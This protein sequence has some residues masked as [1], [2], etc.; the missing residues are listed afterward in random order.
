MTFAWPV[1]HLALGLLA[2]EARGYFT[3]TIIAILKQI[4]SILYNRFYGLMVKRITF[5]PTVAA[6]NIKLLTT[7]Q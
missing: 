7:S 4:S 5:V 3:K 6:H 1:V 2:R